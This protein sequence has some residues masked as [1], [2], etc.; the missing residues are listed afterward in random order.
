MA[1]VRFLLAIV[2]II[3][4]CGGLSAAASELGVLTA[5]YETTYQTRSS[6]E[7][8]SFSRQ[9]RRAA[10]TS[11]NVKEKIEALQL[12]SEIEATRGK[13]GTAIRSLGD[14]IQLSGSL[15]DKLD[16]AQSLK[17]IAG[18]YQ[19]LGA[20][21]KA[22]NVLYLAIKTVEENKLSLPD[23]KDWYHELGMLEGELGNPA[24][25]EKYFRKSLSLPECTDNYD[26][27]RTSLNIVKAL[28]RQRAPFLEQLVA[29][30]EFNQHFTTLSDELPKGILAVELGASL[31]RTR[32]DNSAIRD[33]ASEYLQ[34]GLIIAT[35]RGDAR[36]QS[37]ATGYLGF[38]AIGE[39][40][41]QSALDLS[42]R[43]LLI[44]GRGELPE[45]Q[46]LWQWQIARIHKLQDDPEKSLANYRASLI[47]IESIQ[48]QLMSG[49]RIDFQELVLPVF[50]EMT[51]LLL[52]RAMLATIDSERQL[53]LHEARE[54]MERSHT[55]EILNYFNGDCVLPTTEFALESVDKGSVV[56]YPMALDDR[57]SVLVKFPDGIRQYVA[58]VK[59]TEYR[60]AIDDFRY[61]LEIGDD[62]HLEYA[63]I[64]HGWLIAPIEEK[65]QE[66]DIRN[67]V[68]VPSGLLRTI[69]LS[70]LYDG[71][72]YLIEKYAVTTSL[73]LDLTDPRP[74]QE[75]GYKLLLGGISE[76]VGGFDALPGVVKE[77][78]AIQ[79][80]LNG[81]ILLNSEFSIDSLSS[82][83]G[84]GDYS[85]VH[86]ATH[87]YFDQEPTLS[88]LLTYDGEF[89]LENLQ[90]TV[91]LRRFVDEPLELLVLSAC[92]TA[93]GN[94]LSAL[95]LAGVSLKAGARSTLASLWEIGDEATAK[96]MVQ[97]Y[98]HLQQGSSKSESLRLSQLELMKDPKFDHP[99]FWSPFLL[100][101]NWL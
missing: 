86:L 51:D 32:Q 48:D 20:L 3:I 101:G 35:E 41:Y 27:A 77:L 47:S 18:R 60:Q 53:L 95:G 70:A 15:N 25:A 92:E 17:S 56:I 82:H 68:F 87:G 65:L 12:I 91:G 23:L 8:E 59:K 75:S 78:E 69:P 9:L 62:D 84:V 16:N 80:D 55:S 1:E 89:T 46:Y 50:K 93:L 74:I 10:G 13:K 57:V 72:K 61:A 6:S 94:E 2:L 37:Y 49:S 79:A 96:L 40:D 52:E 64:L 26:R 5:R 22:K 36:Y 21:P 38:L 98:K 4:A 34:K 33:R 39:N 43:A 83:L 30:S 90:E 85:V 29:V 100:I 24:A 7:L 45:L 97:F 76:Q 67:L 28:L 54:T 58:A 31:A 66:F 44:A 71:N 88:F 99:N 63:Q 19:S 42:R 11:N 14:A 73:G 81:D